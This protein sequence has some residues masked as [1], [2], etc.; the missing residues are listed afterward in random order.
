MRLRTRTFT[1]LSVGGLALIAAFMLLLGSFPA[2]PRAEAANDGSLAGTYDIVVSSGPTKYQTI[3]LPDPDV[4]VELDS[5]GQLF[6]TDLNDST[7]GTAADKV[8]PD[9]DGRPGGCDNVRV[10]I[11][12]TGQLRAAY[13]NGSVPP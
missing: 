2:S 8:G 9:A 6:Q 4:L 11:D 13:W 12:P 1:T 5:R 3:V 7:C 10:R